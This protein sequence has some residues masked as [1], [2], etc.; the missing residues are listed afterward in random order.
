MMSKRRTSG[1]GSG[2]TGEMA[3]VAASHMQHL[4]VTDAGGAVV[5]GSWRR[6]EWEWE[7]EWSVVRVE[8]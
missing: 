8:S 1:A 4:R 3:G 7:W 5:S 2:E 6:W